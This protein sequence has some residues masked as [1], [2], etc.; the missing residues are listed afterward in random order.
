MDEDYLA[1][2]LFWHLVILALH[3]LMDEDHLALGPFWHLVVLALHPLID[4]DRNP[5]ILTRTGSKLG[6]VHNPI[7]GKHSNNHITPQP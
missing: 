3:P 6:I 7:T 1:L 2:G 4:E 5:S